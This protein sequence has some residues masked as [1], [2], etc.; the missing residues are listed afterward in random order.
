MGGK[1]RTHPEDVDSD[2]LFSDFSQLSAFR[3]KDKAS[4]TD[5]FLSPPKQQLG[6]SPFYQVWKRLWKRLTTRAFAFS[7]FEV[8]HLHTDRAAGPGGEPP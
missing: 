4:L 6:G 3:S 8:G 2:Y 7:L 5:S 1:K